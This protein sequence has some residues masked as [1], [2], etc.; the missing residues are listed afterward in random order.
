MIRTYDEFVSLLDEKGFMLFSGD[1][2]LSWR[3]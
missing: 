1:G 3:M 2:Y